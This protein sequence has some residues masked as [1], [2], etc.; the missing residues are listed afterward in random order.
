MTEKKETTVPAIFINSRKMAEDLMKVQALKENISTFAKACDALVINSEAT[1]LKATQ[2]LSD[3]N[4]VVKKIDDKRKI[5][6]EPYLKAGKF[7]DAIAKEVTAEAEKVVK[8]G[9]AKIAAYRETLREEERKEISEQLSTLSQAVPEEMNKLQQMQTDFI[10]ELSSMYAKHI[11]AIHLCG[12]T[13]DIEM[14]K[15][16]HMKYS[17]SS[18]SPFMQG[19]INYLK[20]HGKAIF[21]N[22]VL[23]KDM[24]KNYLIKKQ[25][26][27]NWALITEETLKIAGELDMRALTGIKFDPQFTEPAVALKAVQIEA[28]VKPKGRFKWVFEIADF[29]EVP[30]SWKQINK[31]EVDNYIFENKD[32]LKHN[33]VINGVRF[34]QE[35]IIVL[36]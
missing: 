22:L 23:L 20:E 3:L 17:N 34:K 16:W 36:R 11:E 33:I 19:V 21:D 35:E 14:L 28:E 24:R 4:A 32:A 27:T 12:M 7:V 2:M 18:T 8:D 31:E 29:A 10:N 13:T 6:K 25:D 30:E 9:R 26:E 1:E 5:A 15:E